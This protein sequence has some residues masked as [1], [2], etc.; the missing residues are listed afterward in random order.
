MARSTLE[1]QQELGRQA[2]ALRIAADLSQEDLA[3]VVSTS[4][5]SIRRLEA[6]GSVSLATLVAVVRALGREDW[7]DQLDPHG[8]GPSPLELL[9]QR[10]GQPPRRQRVSRRRR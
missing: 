1:S 8:H 10:R 2:R 7:L 5:S 9:R 6:G 4:V 3:D